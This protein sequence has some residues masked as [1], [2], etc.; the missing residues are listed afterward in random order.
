MLDP[1]K[2]G[3]VCPGMKTDGQLEKT[4]I[5]ADIV[6]AYLGRHGI[7]PSRTTD[8]MVLFLFSIGV[9]KGKWGT[10]LNTLLDFKNDYDRNAPLEEVLPER[11]RR[12]RRSA[13]PARASRISATRCGRTCAR[14]GR[15]IGRRRR[16]P[17]CLQPQDDAAARVS[18]V[19]GR[20][21]REGAARQIGRSSRRR[22]RD[23]VS[24]RH[25]DRHARRERGTRR[26]AVADLPAH[27]A[28]V[29]ASLPRIRERGRG[30]RGA[31]RRL[32]R[33]LRQRRQPRARA[34]ASHDRIRRKDTEDSD[35]VPQA[36]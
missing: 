15:G 10:L 14:V 21:R 30:R 9:T 26:R 20:G 6:T 16:T 5:P 2:F 31:R 27:A 8:H 12:P 36:A 35:P 23:P 22:R 1:I 3:I 34:D 7:V 29:R 17:R 28:R 19:D 13:M 24:A 11:R 32:P 33:L 4:G 25:S 18:A